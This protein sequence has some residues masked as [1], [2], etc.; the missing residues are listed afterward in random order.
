MHRQRILGRSLTRDDKEK[1][2][3][4]R[5]AGSIKIEELLV[6]ESFESPAA[7]ENRYILSRI[8]DLSGRRVLD[9]GCGAGE[10]A[11]YFALHGAEVHAADISPEML[12][13]ATQLASRFGV[14]ITAVEA[15]TSQLPLRDQSFDI[16]YGNGVLHHVE[17]EPA[18]AEVYRVLKPGG[19]AAFIEPL[20]YNPVINIYR[21][22]A[23]AVRT[24]EERPLTLPQLRAFSARFAESDH[25]EF[26]LLC[27]MIFFDF[28]LR[29]RWHPSKVRYWKKVVEEGSN[30]RRFFES[31]SRWDERILRA[32][33]LSSLMC[34]STVLVVKK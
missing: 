7:L 8:G 2:F 3:H 29:R 11:I 24:E 9:L 23:R 33:P 20:P 5:W 15:S 16:V 14:R 28:Y 12:N 17:L 21:H 25:R 6:N 26:W 18:A 32:L 27:S 19:L 1:E 34:W 4:D 22:M 31:A 30:Y 13:V 10:A